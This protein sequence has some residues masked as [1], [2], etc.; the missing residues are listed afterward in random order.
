[1]YGSPT[2]FCWREPIIFRILGRNR[3]LT[4]PKVF[5]PTKLFFHSGATFDGILIFAE[6][7]LRALL[8]GIL[9]ERLHLRSWTRH[10]FWLHLR[11]TKNGSSPL[12]L[13]WWS[14]LLRK[15]LAILPKKVEKLEL[16][17][18]KESCQIMDVISN[19]AQHL[20]SSKIFGAHIIVD[21]S[22]PRYPLISIVLI[23]IPIARS[24]RTPHITPKQSAQTLILLASFFLLSIL[25]RHAQKMLASSYGR[26][27]P[28]THSQG[29]LCSKCS[30]P[31]QEPIGL[32]RSY[33][34]PS[35]STHANNGENKGAYGQQVQ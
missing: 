18:L 14:R 7:C 22:M 28:I 25:W 15:H 2:I 27:F 13:L 11:S 8:V 21:I 6:H 5:T 4:V 1:V 32:R 17:P 29:Y 23:S 35:Q 31:F 30:L 34:K 24:I 20:F 26:F 19:R 3:R 16:K 33:E 10:F 9:Y 12:R